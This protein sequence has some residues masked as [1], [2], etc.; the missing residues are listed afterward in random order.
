[1]PAEGMIFD[2]GHALDFAGWRPFEKRERTFWFG[3]VELVLLIGTCFAS[4]IHT[5][6]FIRLW[7]EFDP[8]F[9]SSFVNV[10][11]S[12]RQG[13][14]QLFPFMFPS[15]NMRHEITPR[16]SPITPF[17]QISQTHHRKPNNHNSRRKI[18]YKRHPE[19]KH[20][21]RKKQLIPLDIIIFHLH[22]SPLPTPD[23]FCNSVDEET[24]LGC[25]ASDSPQHLFSAGREFEI[26]FAK[27]DSGERDDVE[28][29]VGALVEI[30][31]AGIHIIWES[32]YRPFERAVRTTGV[33][34]ETHYMSFGLDEI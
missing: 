5:L 2:H 33:G 28:T 12:I 20:P 16:K 34:P 22:L 18:R 1:M 24:A 26:P 29:E 13:F 19:Q 31:E 23:R 6:S 3:L 9:S 17:G 15:T 25:R 7:T 21:F 10:F 32:L 4:L 11:S 27:R 8:P 14:N 30:V